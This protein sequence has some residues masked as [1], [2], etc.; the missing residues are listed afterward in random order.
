MVSLECPSY[1]LKKFIVIVVIATAWGHKKG[2]AIATKNALSPR[3]RV[4]PTSLFPV[5]ERLQKE[6]TPGHPFKAFPQ[7]V[8]AP[9]I[10]QGYHTLMLTCGLGALT[11][12]T[13]VMPFFEGETMT[14]KSGK[15]SHLQFADS[16][17]SAPEL[18]HPTIQN[19]HSQ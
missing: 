13:V 19:L 3:D 12:N 6:F 7:V 16:E 1:D 14:T 15:G 18:I 2:G 4:Q 11:P 5:G 9:R 8:S 10:R 17:F